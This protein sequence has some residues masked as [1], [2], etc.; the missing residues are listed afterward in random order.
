M[1]N[2]KK[3]LKAEDGVAAVEFAIWLT[4]AVP[5]FIATIDF[6]LYNIDRINLNKAT[7]EVA[8]FA[9]SSR[10]DVDSQI[11]ETIRNIIVSSSGLDAADLTVEATCNGSSICSDIDRVPACLNTANSVIGFT[12]N[13][14]PNA[15]CPDGTPPGYFLTIDVTAAIDPFFG[16]FVSPPDEAMTSVTVKLE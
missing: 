5:F 6:A 9:F 12:S 3:I 14:N 4:F 2:F 15:L 13:N 11:G 10:A 1:L 7:G 16:S 8:V